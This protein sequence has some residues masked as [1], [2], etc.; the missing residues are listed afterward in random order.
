MA[1]RG[2]ATEPAAEGTPAEVAGTAAKPEAS[3]A[4]VES[5]P[6]SVEQQDE[7]TAPEPAVVPEPEPAGPEFEV[8][9]CAVLRTLDG[10]ERY[11]YGPVVIDIDA[12]TTES[13]EHAISVGAIVKHTN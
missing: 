1:A 6:E 9:A 12:F 2:K 11:I 10:S 8:Q 7:A 5:P 13:V 3:P 4:T